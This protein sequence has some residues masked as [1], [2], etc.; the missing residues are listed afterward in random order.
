ML[1]GEGVAQLVVVEEVGEEVP[2]LAGRQPAERGE[3]GVEAGVA[4]EAGDRLGELVEVT[5]RIGDGPLDLVVDLA[6]QAE[7]G[8][9]ALDLGS[10]LLDLRA[11]PAY[12]CGSGYRRPSSGVVANPPPR[13]D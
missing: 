4:R 1:D 10:Q 2:L 13:S 6:G 5:Q 11:P 9:G 8:P 3:D 12:H 7:V